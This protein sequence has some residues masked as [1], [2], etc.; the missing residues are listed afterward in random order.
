MNEFFITCPRGVVDLV[1]L[2]CESF[3]ISGVI[4][5]PGGVRFTGTLEE[6]Y[7]CCYQS[8]VASRVLMKLTDFTP[9]D[10]D[11]LYTTT[12]NI[13]W[14]DHINEGGSLAVDCTTLH[15][16]LNNNHYAA[17][18]IKDAIVDQLRD[19]T[20]SRPDIDRDRPDIR[21]NAYISEK[22]SSL[23]IDLSGEA[24]HK[25][26]YRKQTGP[27]P[28]RENLAAALLMRCKWP[29]LASQGMTLVDPMCGSG[30]LL[31]EAALMALNIAPGSFREFYGLLNWKQHDHATWERVCAESIVKCSSAPGEFSLIG[32]DKSSS[33]I[34]VA[35]TNINAAGLD[36]YITLY[37]ADFTEPVPGLEHK[38]GILV[39]N[40]PYGKRMEDFDRLKSTY[41]ELGRIMKSNYPGWSAAILTSDNELARC[42]GLRAHHKNTL[43][44]GQI[45]C[46]LYQYKINEVARESNSDLVK[47][48][49]DHVEMFRNRLIKNIKHISRWAKKN[50]ISCYRIYDAD[51]PQYSMAIDLYED[52]VHVQEYQPPKT[53]N[54]VIAGHRLNDAIACIS[55]LL[56]IDMSHIAV[57]QRKIQSGHKQYEKHKNINKT[58]VIN[59]GGY[60]FSVNL[61]DYLDTGIFLDHR[62]VRQLIK[63]NARD[64]DFLN[65][66]SYTGTATIYAVAGGAR[67]TTSVDMSNTY[68]NWTRENLHL[69]SMNEEKNS[70][71]RADCLQW[72]RDDDSGGQYHLILLD[73]PTFS[74]SKKMEQTLDIQR[75]HIELIH[76]AMKRLD[77]KGTLI[78]S[79]NA[80]RFVL[81]DCLADDYYIQ[82]ISKLTTSEDFRRHPLHQCWILSRQKSNEGFSLN[83]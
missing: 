22:E 17:L 64:K 29:A 70:L 67:S 6:A 75:D 66:F 55:Q 76:L 12:Q 33:V 46:T 25:R 60:K 5:L 39:A 42:I 18:K 63:R 62:N 82:C 56:S 71:V 41:T 26:G 31:I 15:E 13:D 30:T 54:E 38:K 16:Q 35:A 57:K 58:L 27:A 36:D 44:N 72:L 49:A 24:L 59:E 19:A 74:N 78:F 51:I 53:V 37:N 11:D 69:N 80:S 14:S 8:R 34:N 61:H 21:V 81:N 77:E 1:E 2:E 3:G 9:A 83:L 73:P 40:P 43:Y 32:T 47:G 10:Y 4:A 79:C 28:L 68:L 52:W 23:Y 20:G 45:K 50:N 48:E 7:R 65:L